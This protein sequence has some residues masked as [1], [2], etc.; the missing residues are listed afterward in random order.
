M[1]GTTV[2]VRNRTNS[3]VVSAMSSGEPPLRWQQAHINGPFRVARKDRDLP[4]R[5]SMRDSAPSPA[6][7][8]TQHARVRDVVTSQSGQTSLALVGALL[9]LKTM[10]AGLVKSAIVQKKNEKNCPI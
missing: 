3:G 9:T 2:W 6:T 4:V 5:G 8:A 10:E 1:N 7:V